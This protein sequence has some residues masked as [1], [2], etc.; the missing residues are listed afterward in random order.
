MTTPFDSAAY[1]ERRYGAGGASGTGSEGRLAGFKA[2]FVNAFM[3]HN[4]VASLLDLGC[5]D[6][7][8]AA[9]LDVANYVGVDVSPTTIARC[10]RRF[11]GDPRRRFQLADAPLQPAE[12]ALSMDILFHLV[13]DTVFDTY[14]DRLFGSATRY[15]LV[16]ASNV[17]LAWPVPHVRHRA[18]TPLVAARFPDWRLA[19]HIPNLFPYDPARPDETSFADFFVY[20]R[21]GERCVLEI[22]P[23]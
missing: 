13:E 9:L 21:P 10:R 14:L 2:G 4:G 11:A 17:D 20:T 16:Y 18:F 1:W 19:A 23:A 6:G 5:G 15:V 12:L 8:Q 7:R 3:R 22:P